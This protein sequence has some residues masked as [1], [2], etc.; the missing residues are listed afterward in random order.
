[1]I[2]FRYHIVSIVSIFIALA[3]GIVLGA[4]PLQGEIG[5]TLQSEV[6][7]LR[8]DK[9]ALNEDL[10]RAR[11]EL[12][13]RDAYLAAVSGRVLQGALEGQRVAL[14]VLPGADGAVSE[15]VVEAVDSAGGRVT[16]TTSVAN[17]WVTQEA[18]AAA[19]RDELVAEVA[20]GAG[21]DLSSGGDGRPEDV[22]LSR[23]LTRT[24]TLGDLGP[25]DGVAAEAMQRLAEGGVLSFDADEF[26]RAEM[27]VVVG[28]AVTDGTEEEQQAVAE[29]WAGLADTLQVASRGAVVASD[30]SAEAE[31]VSVVATV[32]DDA[33]AADTVSTVDDAGDPAGLASVV[34]ALVEQAG[35][36]SG[37]YGVGP[38]ADAPFAPVPGS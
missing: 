22:L 14:V 19:S 30:T 23:L 6:A 4:G 12:D 9:T 25:D 31:G 34:F 2:D 28:G 18:E 24:A 5:S 3:V 10:D 29:R 15:S 32:R 1:M 35:G 20:S 7:G 21:V 38:G 8:D 13:Q 16:S 17:E 37:H 33:D 26:S 36:G 11:A 27:A